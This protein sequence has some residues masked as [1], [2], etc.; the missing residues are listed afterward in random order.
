MKTVALVLAFAVAL[1]LGFKLAR[2]AQEDAVFDGDYIY[3]TSCA[4]CHGE[5]GLGVTLFGP[6]LK[7]DAFITQGD[8]QAIAK[9]IQMGRKYRDKLYPDYMGMPRFQ[10][11]RAR[12]TE[13]LI[14]YLKGDLQTSTT[15]EPVGR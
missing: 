5:G 8:N 11:I 12:Q 3:D 6:P 9:V 15:P 7:G 10:F 14:A 1:G 2:G 4:S 13:D